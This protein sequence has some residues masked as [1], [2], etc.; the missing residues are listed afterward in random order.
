MIYRFGPF[1]LDAADCTLRRDG[2]PVPVE[3]QVFDLLHLL[4]AEAGHLVGRDRL[5]ERVWQGRIVS[6]ATIS[7]RIAAARRA[8]DDDGSRQAVI[9]TV[10]RRGVRFV[11]PVTHAETAPAPAARAA[12]QTIRM[13]RAPDGTAIAYAVTGTGP[14]LL[15]AGHFLTHLEHDRESPVW[16]PLIDRLSGSFTLVRYDQR[17][18]GLSDPAPPALTLDALADDLEAVADAAGLDRFP[19]FAASQGVPVAIAFAVRRPE[20]VSRLVLY[21]GYA[22][23]RLARGDAAEHDNAE[24]MLTMIRQGWGRAGGAFAAAFA[25]VY[26]P[27]AE[28]AD[29]RHMARMQLASATPENA[30]ALRIA[31]DRFDVGALLPRVTAPTLVVHC[32]EDA[33][34]PLCQAR[35]LAA[36]IPGAELRVLSGRNHVPLPRDP[37][38]AALMLAVEDFAALRE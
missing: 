36:G 27:D 16:R 33:V 17:S 38:W 29:L 19:V 14:P 23:G 26:M 34:H 22:Q 25:T 2:A 24:A 35:R 10:P 9:R 7:S 18:T 4:V 30:V 21:G 37:A 3:P 8:V 32:D 20:R 28:R 11:A 1:E 13:T 15:R 31:I 12:G 5:I 6:E